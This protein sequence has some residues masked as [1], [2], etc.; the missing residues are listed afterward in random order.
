M[1]LGHC[2]SLLLMLTFRAAKNQTKVKRT[3]PFL[4]L[5]T[6]LS[7]LSGYLLSKASLVGRTGINLFYKEYRFLKTWYKGAALVLGVWLLLFFL[8]RLAQNKLSQS[9]AKLVHVL[10]ILAALVGLYFTYADFRNTLSH[11]LL[12]ERF[13]L[14]A[15]L[16]WIGWLLIAVFHLWPQKKK[17]AFL[18]Q[19][20]TNL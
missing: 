9:R 13:H 7:V 15:Y 10:A 1:L 3:A 8:H 12:G 11:Q 2:T 16:F 5:L 6:G 17:E 14:G 19:T 20:E 4:L 18:P